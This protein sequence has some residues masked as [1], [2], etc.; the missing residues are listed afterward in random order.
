MAVIPET[1]MRNTMWEQIPANEIIAP[2]SKEE[3]SE[4]IAGANRDRKTVLPIGGGNDLFTANK[5]FDI[6]IDLKNLASCFRHTPE[7]LTATFPA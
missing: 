4:I 6:G 7:D 1:E 3:I 5:Q 2:E